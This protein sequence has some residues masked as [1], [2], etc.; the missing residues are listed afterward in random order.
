[1][2]F[3]GGEPLLRRDLEELMR[4]GRGA[5]VRRYG[6]VTNGALVEPSR[7]RSLRRAGRLASFPVMRNRLVFLAA[8]LAAVKDA[9]GKKMNGDKVAALVKSK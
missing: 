4:A 6:L 1:M 5:G 8:A 7:A 9:M 3:S 2:A